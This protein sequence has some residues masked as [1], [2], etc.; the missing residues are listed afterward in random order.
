M[1]F[2]DIAGPRNFEVLSAE[3][4]VYEILYYLSGLVYMGLIPTKG[5]DF[6]LCHNIQTGV[7]SFTYWLS[8]A[9]KPYE[10]EADH[11]RFNTEVMTV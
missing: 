8:T 2:T 10:C 11:S 3:F 6:S 9:R 4:N 1:T 7:Q 5:S